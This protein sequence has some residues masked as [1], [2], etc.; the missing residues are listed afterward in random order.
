MGDVW[1]VSWVYGWV[2]GLVG[3]D[4]FIPGDCGSRR[5]FDG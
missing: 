3:D 1:I 5:V 2:S 4:V